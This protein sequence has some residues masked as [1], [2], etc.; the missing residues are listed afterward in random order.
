MVSKL[1]QMVTAEDL[2]K[3]D[4]DALDIDSN[5]MHFPIKDN[6]YDDYLN[7][8]IPLTSSHN[9]DH[10]CFKCEKL[11]QQKPI[12]GI[13]YCRSR[14]SDN[15]KAQMVTKSSFLYARILFSAN[16]GCNQVPFRLNLSIS[17]SKANFNN[18]SLP[19][20]ANCMVIN[21]DSNS[22][23]LS[24]NPYF[25]NVN[26]SEHYIKKEQRLAFPGDRRNFPGFEIPKDGIL[27]LAIETS[28]NVSQ[29]VFQLSFDLSGLEKG[30]RMIL[31]Y[32]IFKRTQY[33]VQGSEHLKIVKLNRKLSEIE[34]KVTH[35]ENAYYLYDSA[36]MLFHTRSN[37]A[38]RYRSPL[39]V[40]E[41]NSLDRKKYPELDEKDILIPFKIKNNVTMV[42]SEQYK[43]D[44]DYFIRKCEF[45]DES[46]I[47][48]A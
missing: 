34:I 46:D 38:N 21:S 5:S 20:F 36:N 16:S 33:T 37:T 14:A 24:G 9:Y 42:Q 11:R 41:L 12:Y 44:V 10:M 7:Y 29:S 15:A 35:L 43:L 22:V 40:K 39:L 2:E 27:K 25:A 1:Q 18:L 4:V 45:C 48:Y 26:I 30:N 13:Q 47:L 32:T 28:E 31:K 3:K 6:I 17:H 23:D 19:L 8:V